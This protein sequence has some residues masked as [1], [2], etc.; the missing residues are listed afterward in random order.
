MAL[1]L[2]MVVCDAFTGNMFQPYQQNNV[3]KQAEINQRWS[4]TKNS[5][6]Y[7]PLICF[8]ITIV[9]ALGRVHVAISGGMDSVVD[10]KPELVLQMT[11]PHSKPTLTKT[12]KK[13]EPMLKDAAANGTEGSARTRP[14]SCSA[15]GPPWHER[16]HGE[17]DDDAA[18][19]R[20][21]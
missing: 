15:L 5:L 20:D 11:K 7:R 13:S 10:T 14:D 1:P 18:A 12:K 9:H 21:V 2:F 16:H 6:F 4:D 3:T 17:N 8:A 19:V